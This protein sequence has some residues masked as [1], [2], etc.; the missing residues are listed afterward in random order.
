[1]E[2][3]NTEELNYLLAEI[4]TKEKDYEKAC[5]KYES[6]IAQDPKNIDYTINLTNIYIT[7]HQYLKARQVLKNHIKNNPQDK[8]NP[9][10]QAYGILRAFL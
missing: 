3:Q 4:Y 5:A 10:F 9:R 8:N 1:M 6:L 7:N 2:I